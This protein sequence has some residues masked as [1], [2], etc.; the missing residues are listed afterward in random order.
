MTAASGPNSNALNRGSGLRYR[1][2]TSAHMMNSSSHIGIPAEDLPENY[3]M[4]EDPIELNPQSFRSFAP[5]LVENYYSN[6]SST[7]MLNV[8]AGNALEQ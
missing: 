4:V 5:F 1:S 7:S 8:S 3:G 2:L 6:K